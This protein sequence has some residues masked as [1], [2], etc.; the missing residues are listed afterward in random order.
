MSSTSVL[1]PFE[2]SCMHNKL[3]NLFSKGHGC[4]PFYISKKAKEKK[5]FFLEISNI[6]IDF[7]FCAIGSFVLVRIVDCR[8]G[9]I[10]IEV[11]FDLKQPRTFS[12]YSLKDL[13]ETL[14]VTFDPL[15]PLKV[16]KMD[17]YEEA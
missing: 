14:W 11:F 1:T 5:T 16:L 15:R 4:I 9:Q 17:F 2:K 13:F 8:V 12:F 6:Q 7:I 10:F 3:Q